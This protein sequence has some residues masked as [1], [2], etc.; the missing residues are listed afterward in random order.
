MLMVRKVASKTLSMSHW[1]VKEMRI[2][3]PVWTNYSISFHVQ[4]KDEFTGKESDQ[5]EHVSPCRWVNTD[6]YLSYYESMPLNMDK[7][8][9][10]DRLIRNGCDRD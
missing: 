7:F 9:T 10:F 1:L 4:E 5:Y 8:Y 2:E 3:K 6:G